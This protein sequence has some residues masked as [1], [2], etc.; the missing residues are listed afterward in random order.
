MPCLAAGTTIF[1]TVIFVLLFDA[2]EDV[3]FELLNGLNFRHYFL[4]FFAVSESGVVTAPQGPRLT[5]QACPLW[6]NVSSILWSSWGSRQIEHRFS[7]SKV[8]FVSP[9]YIL[10][11]R[12]DFDLS[13]VKMIFF[14]LS[15][16]FHHSLEVIRLRVPLK[17]CVR[18]FFVIDF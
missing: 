12:T 3:V 8:I 4:A 1:F 10:N 13:R 2:W 16:F 5:A 14:D 11:I 6:K 18:A 15:P 7:F 9:C 17:V